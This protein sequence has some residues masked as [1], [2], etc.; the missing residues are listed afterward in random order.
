MR[1]NDMHDIQS[2][3]PQS[4]KIQ[5]GLLEGRKYHLPIPASRR[6]FRRFQPFSAYVFK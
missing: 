2:I 4:G 6:P 3:F 5:S 1:A